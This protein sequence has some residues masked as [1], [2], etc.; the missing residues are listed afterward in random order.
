MLPKTFAK[1]QWK[2]I[3]LIS[4][5]KNNIEEDLGNNQKRPNEEC[6]SP[7]IGSFPAFPKNTIVH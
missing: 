6:E 4:W 2:G 1:S 3:F 7:E 5:L